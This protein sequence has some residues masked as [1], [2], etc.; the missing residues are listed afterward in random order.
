MSRW[1]EITPTTVS[2][3]HFFL[4]NRIEPWRCYP[5]DAIRSQVFVFLPHDIVARGD[6]DRLHDQEMSMGGSLVGRKA[7]EVHRW[8]EW[9][10][11]KRS[12]RWLD[13]DEFI[14]AALHEQG[15][16][17]QV[18]KTKLRK[19]ASRLLGDHRARM[20]QRVA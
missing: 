15:T 10:R 16:S 6:E 19:A 8:A 11:A 17:P 2:P 14:N 18:T 13:V 12:L 5:Y 9:Y 1:G 7:D 4:Q 20:H 3:S